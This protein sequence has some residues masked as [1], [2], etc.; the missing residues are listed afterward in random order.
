MFSLNWL[1]VAIGL[2]TKSVETANAATF[3]M[4]FL[5]YVS[6]SFIPTETMP[7]WLHA[8]AENQPMT[9]LIETVRGLLLGTPIDNN[10]W[11]TLAWFGGLFI[12]S[13]VLATLLF[14]KR[15]QN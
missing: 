5:P 6:S 4:L 13:F 1:F 7:S 15:K 12:I 9:P 11:L 14:K 3:P 8:L 10:L 2:L